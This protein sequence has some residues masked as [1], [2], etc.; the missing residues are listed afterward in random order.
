MEG[1]AL[2]PVLARLEGAQD[3]MSVKRVF[4]EP[5]RADD[6]T[7]IPAAAIAGG[8]GAGG[9]GGTEPDGRGRGSGAG[10]GFGLN[11]RP[12]GAFIVK[13]GT[14]SWRP[15]VDLL[16]IIMGAQAVTLAAL[17]TARRALGRRRRHH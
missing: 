13:D 5:Y 4:G 14:V 10:L 3:A 12:V 8:A 16:P 17:V 11:A 15:A 2:T 7:V 9:G 6:V 1:S